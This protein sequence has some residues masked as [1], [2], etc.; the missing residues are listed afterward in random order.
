MSPTCEERTP[1]DGPLGG[2]SR[3]SSGDGRMLAA[4]AEAAGVGRGVTRGVPRVVPR[5]RAFGVGCAYDWR[6]AESAEAAYLAKAE[7]W[8]NGSDTWPCRSVVVRL[9]ADS[10]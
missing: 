5:G 4:A 9:D 3:S 7:A 10:R 1:S 8:G 2:A 6:R